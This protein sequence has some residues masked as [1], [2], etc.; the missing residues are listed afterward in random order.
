MPTTIEV[1]EDELWIREVAKMPINKPTNGLEVV[2]IR[3]SAK[4]LPKSFRDDPIKLMLSKK[5]YRK[6]SS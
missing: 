5:R 2:A 4:P 6:R 3:V 1:V